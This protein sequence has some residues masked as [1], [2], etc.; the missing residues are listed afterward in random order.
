M[1]QCL[2]VFRARKGL[3]EQCLC[4]FRARKGLMEVYGELDEVDSIDWMKISNVDVSNTRS[5]TSAAEQTTQRHIA[6]NRVA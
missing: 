2:C 1:E 4:V 3:M 5:F 6:T